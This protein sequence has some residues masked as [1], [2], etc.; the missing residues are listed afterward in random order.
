ME[1]AIT[2]Q[3]IAD[4]D[5]NLMVTLDHSGSDELAQLTGCFNVFVKKIRN[6]TLLSH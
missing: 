2:M 3:N 1:T 6:L 4:G 5:D